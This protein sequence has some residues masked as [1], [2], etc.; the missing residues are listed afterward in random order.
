MVEYKQRYL[1][2]GLVFVKAMS[3]SVLGNSYMGQKVNPMIMCTV[4]FEVYVIS[5]ASEIVLGVNYNGGEGQREDIRL[6]GE[7]GQH[8][9]HRRGATDVLRDLG[10]GG[11]CG[12]VQREYVGLDCGPGRGCCGHVVRVQLQGAEVQHVGR[13]LDRLSSRSTCFGHRVDRARGELHREGHHG[14]HGQIGQYLRAIG[15]GGDRFTGVAEHMR[16]ACGHLRGTDAFD[17][18]MVRA[19]RECV[20]GPQDAFDVAG[21]Q[22]GRGRL[23]L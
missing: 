22:A 16:Q 3:G 1:G 13:G 5:G 19:L 6:G 17:A 20:P 14:C 23:W 8:G 18:A 11:D 12:R 10:R 21:A 4:R 2:S 9:E 7:Q 15:I